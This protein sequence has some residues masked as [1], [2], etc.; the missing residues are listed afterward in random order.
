M[1][2][3]SCVYSVQHMPA[4]ICVCRS[5]GPTGMSDGMGGS[6]SLRD[7]AEVLSCHECCGGVGWGGGGREDHNF[8]YADFRAGLAGNIPSFPLYST[9]NFGLVRVHMNVEGT[10]VPGVVYCSSQGLA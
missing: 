2:A 8:I 9:L 4:Y 7:E 10:S 5:S 3:C 6:V 1:R